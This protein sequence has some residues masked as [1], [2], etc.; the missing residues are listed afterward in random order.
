METLLET[1]LIGEARVTRAEL[2]IGDIS[3]EALLFAESKIGMRK[4]IAVRCEGLACEV[5]G[6]LADLHHILLCSLHHGSQIL[7]ILRAERL[8]V[9][10]DLM[11]VIDQ[12]LSVIALNDTMR[13]RHLGGFIIREIALDLF[14][15]FAQL[16]FILLEEGIETFDLACQAIPLPLASFLLGRRCILP[17]M[18]S[19][20][21]FELFL[22]LVAFVLEFLKRTTPFLG[23]VGG[24][25][26]TIQ[27]EVGTSKE[28]QFITDQ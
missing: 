17:D 11:L 18:L 5:V 12:S 1:L 23:G 10:D 21:L 4:I 20:L 2:D 25:F 26:E 8:G 7:V 6:V 13:G 28:I 15:A 3:I 24:Q 9:Q 27:T 16:G 22:E 19:D 14:G